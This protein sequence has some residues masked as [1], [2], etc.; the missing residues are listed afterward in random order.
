LK[1]KRA[2]NRRFLQLLVSSATTQES[3]R[4]KSEEK[5]QKFAESGTIFY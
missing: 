3:G 1:A 2:G 5:Y 4:K